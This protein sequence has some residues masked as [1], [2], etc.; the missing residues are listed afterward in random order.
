MVLMRSTD[1]SRARP[2][3]RRLMRSLTTFDSEPHGQNGGRWIPRPEIPLMPLLSWNTFAS[4]GVESA[5]AAIDNGRVVYVA[6]GRI[7]MAHALAVAKVKP[8]EKV[9]VPAYHCISMVE[10]ILHAGAQPV[11]YALHDDL[12]ADL[13]DVAAK[14][15][16]DTHALLAVNY[17]GFP[18]DLPRVRSFCDERGLRFIEDCAHSF[19]GSCA[20]K[21]LGTFGDF[22]IASLT[23]FFPVRDGGCLIIPHGMG[24]AARLPL[25][26]QGFMASLA[27]L[28]NSLEDA[29]ALGRLTQV[30]PVIALLKET[31]RVIRA[32][33]PTATSRLTENPAQQ[34][35]GQ[36][37][38]FDSTWMGIRSTAASRIISAYASRAH[39]V[40]TRRAHY[41]QLVRE[42]TGVSN[43]RPLFPRLPDN[44]VP[45][46]FPLLIDSLPNVFA[47]LEDRAVPMQRFG[48][49][50]WPEMSGDVCGLTKHLSTHLIQLPCHQELTQDEVTGL[51]DRVRTIVA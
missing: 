18:Q 11:F 8:G 30:A 21:P 12:T 35:S 23:K 1:E 48:Q 34:R 13:D 24:D 15:D 28:L 5:P 38:G 37:G 9:L 14:I 51:A 4:D 50:P 49:F 39:I 27:A 41:A 47:A 7:A 16:A 36:A 44:V 29:V 10:P 25:R 46:M 40:A 42:F 19:F 26:S 43:C 20:G 6:A 3:V 45:Y 31:K 33:A 2:P 22:A 17:F 32:V